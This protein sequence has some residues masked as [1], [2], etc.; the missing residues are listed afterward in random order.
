MFKKK[1]D[2]K[3]VHEY[4]NGL[5]LPTSQH[6]AQTDPCDTVL[7]ASMGASEFY[8]DSISGTYLTNLDS[9]ANVERTVSY[10]KLPHEEKRA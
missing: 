10:K 2:G 4:C 8:P 3:T 7:L 1:R 6:M 5:Y 9:I